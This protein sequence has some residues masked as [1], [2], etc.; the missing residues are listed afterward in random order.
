MSASASFVSFES[1][2]FN[3]AIAPLLLPC[4]SSCAAC[5]FDA[6]SALLVSKAKVPSLIPIYSPSGALATPMPLDGTVTVGVGVLLPVVVVPLPRRLFTATKAS[7]PSSK[8]TNRNSR[9]LRATLL[10][11]CCLGGG[12]YTAPGCWGGGGGTGVKGGRR[13]RVRWFA[14]VLAMLDPPA[15]PAA[16]AAAIGP[17]VPRV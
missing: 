14:N 15:V 4:V 17:D 13:T 2:S 5:C 16:P 8:I 3:V 10:P 7:T 11:P 9:K 12:E 1:P 6:P